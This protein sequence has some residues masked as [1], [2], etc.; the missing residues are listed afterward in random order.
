MIEYVFV[1]D[2][3]A[4]VYKYIAGTGITCQKQVEKRLKNKAVKVLPIE[5]VFSDFSFILPLGVSPTTY[6]GKI[7]W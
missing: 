1:R 3:K 6:R 7:V 5:I 2:H 4:K